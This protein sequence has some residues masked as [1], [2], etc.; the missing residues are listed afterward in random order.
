MKEYRYIV[1]KN[2]RKDTV[3][4]VARKDS[5]L[6]FKEKSERIY[7]VVVFFTLTDRASTIPSSIL[8]GLP[9]RQYVV[10]WTGKNRKIYKE[11]QRDNENITLQKQDKKR[12]E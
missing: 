5:L 2:G 8:R 9:I 11:L 7:A 6:L 12:Q 4:V 3:V 10:C 1:T